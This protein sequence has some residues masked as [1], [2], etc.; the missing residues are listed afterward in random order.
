[1][2]RECDYQPLMNSVE[3]RTIGCPDNLYKAYKAKAICPSCPKAR[4][5]GN[6]YRADVNAF[7][8]VKSSNVVSIGTDPT[9]LIEL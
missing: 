3:G 6:K 9:L 4:G 5:F 8:E 7:I 2:T 1:M